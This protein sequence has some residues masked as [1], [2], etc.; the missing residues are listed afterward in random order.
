MPM[1]ASKFEFARRF[2]FLLL[3]CRTLFLLVMVFELSLCQGD[4]CSA[5]G[6]CVLPQPLKHFSGG[7]QDLDTMLLDA[8]CFMGCVDQV[9][10]S[11]HWLDYILYCIFL[12]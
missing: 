8:Q 3:M 10:S 4:E 11:N 1:I 2:S 12:P 6:S 9:S 5:E 7:G